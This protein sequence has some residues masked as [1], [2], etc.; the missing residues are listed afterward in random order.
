MAATALCWASY[1]L[2]VCL[3]SGAWWRSLGDIDLF[4]LGLVRTAG[5]A[6]AAAGM[7]AVLALTWARTA[8]PHLHDNSAV[9]F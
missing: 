1:G 7:A 8:G 6:A 2:A 3:C 4:H 5:A 9:I